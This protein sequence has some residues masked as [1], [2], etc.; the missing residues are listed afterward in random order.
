MV[1][2]T[3]IAAPSSTKNKD[4][5]RDPWMHQ[6]QRGNQWHFGMKAHIGVDVESGGLVHTAIGT[7]TKVNDVTRA[8]N[9]LH[10]EEIDAWGDAGYQGV[11]KREELKDSKVRWDVALRPGK[12]RTLDKRKIRDAKIQRQ[13]DSKS[14]FRFASRNGRCADQSVSLGGR[15]IAELSAC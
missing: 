7:A 15:G 3:I 12:R 5:Q 4:G 14:A 9:L 2:A 10:G 1:D 6:T 13:F 11:N 8:G